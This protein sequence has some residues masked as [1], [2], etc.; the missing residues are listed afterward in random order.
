MV[1]GGYTFV[2]E[3]GIYDLK[4]R[5]TVENDGVSS[6]I[7]ELAVPPPWTRRRRG[8]RSSARCSASSRRTSLEAAP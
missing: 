5:W 7:A 3:F 6:D 1:D 8:S 2:P 4:R